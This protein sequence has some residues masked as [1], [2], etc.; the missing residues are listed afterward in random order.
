MKLILIGPSGS[1]KGSLAEFLVR[2]FKIPHI[3][4]GAIFRD[5]I[6]RKTPLGIRVAEL[7]NNGIFVPDEITMEMLFER[8]RKSDCKKG[9][10]LDG[11]PRTVNQAEILAKEVDVDLV[12]ELDASDEVVI[13]RLAGRYMCSACNVI[14][15]IRYEDVTKCKSCG[16]AQLYQRDDDKEESIKIRLEQYHEQSGPILEFY[17]K[18]GKLF[19]VHT[20]ADHKPPQ[21]YEI[22]KNEIIQYTTA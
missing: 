18:Q 20:K 4:T 3:S 6:A 21:V 7:V 9:F 16:G 19:T 22:V 11:V 2:D 17:R 13:N 8:L 1:G 10:I 12:I 15:N 14:H 5:N